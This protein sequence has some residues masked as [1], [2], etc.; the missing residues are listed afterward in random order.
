MRTIPM[1]TAL[2]TSALTLAACT[3][4]APDYRACDPDRSSELVSV[5]AFEGPLEGMEATVP[6]VIAEIE[7]TPGPQP[8][9]R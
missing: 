4:S 3:Y 2:L 9:S 7:V 8:P 1:R 6:D 5:S